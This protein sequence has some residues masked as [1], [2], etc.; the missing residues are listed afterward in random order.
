MKNTM[1]FFAVCAA[2]VGSAFLSSSSYYAPG[3]NNGVEVTKK[4]DVWYLG[5]CGVWIPTVKSHEIYLDDTR[6]VIHNMWQLPEGHC[7]IPTDGKAARYPNLIVTPNGTAIG[8]AMMRP[9]R[10]NK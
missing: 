9:E 10:G 8:K 7:L 6:V 4:N 2:I 3:D 1:K 5:A